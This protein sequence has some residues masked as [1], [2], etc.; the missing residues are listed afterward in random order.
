MITSINPHIG[1]SDVNNEWHFFTTKVGHAV[2]CDWNSDPVQEV[3]SQGPSDTKLSSDTDSKNLPWPAGDYMLNIESEECHYKCD[4]TNPGRLFCPKKEVACRED[5]Q[6]SRSEGMLKCGA[7][8]FF[9]AAVFC[10]F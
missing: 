8:N 4:G 7:Y 2:E 6:K 10:D 1:G 5:S 3:T 9:H